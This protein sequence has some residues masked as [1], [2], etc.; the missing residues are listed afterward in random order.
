MPRYGLE[1]SFIHPENGMTR[2]DMQAAVR[3]ANKL[4]EVVIFRSTGP[5][6]RRWIER[7]YPTKNFHVKGKS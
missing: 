5:W 2:G 3:T 6:S 7:R 1:A 4:D